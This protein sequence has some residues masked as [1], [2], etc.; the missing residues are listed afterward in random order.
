VVLCRISNINEAPRVDRDVLRIIKFSIPFSL[1]AP[2]AQKLTFR[3]KF[4]DAGIVNIDYK[5]NTIFIY[6]YTNGSVE[7]S[8]LRAQRPPFIYE[9]TIRCEFKNLV[10]VDVCHIDESCVVSSD[11]SG[12]EK[13]TLSN[14]IA[15]PFF[16]KFPI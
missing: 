4:L 14:Y 2:F 13:T 3:S 12:I 5:N 7:S 10:I 15:D 1:A 11:A 16:Y 6:C 8:I 9:L